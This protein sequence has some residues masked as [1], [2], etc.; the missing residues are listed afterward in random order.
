MIRL[1]SALDCSRRRQVVA[2]TA[3]LGVQEGWGAIEHRRLRAQI[4]LAKLPG[5]LSSLLSDRWRVCPDPCERA[6]PPQHTCRARGHRRSV[7][8][9]ATLL[10]E[11]AWLSVICE[12][13]GVRR[14]GAPRPFPEAFKWAI[15]LFGEQAA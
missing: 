10:E 9:C 5:G 7:A 3:V 14:S 12:V 6:T 13:E 2:C 8:G 4:G 1:S 15:G 11:K